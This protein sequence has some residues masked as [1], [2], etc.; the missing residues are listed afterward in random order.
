M[1]LEYSTPCEKDAKKKLKVTVGLTSTD[2]GPDST[3]R[4]LTLVYAE[5]SSEW[6]NENPDADPSPPADIGELK[7]IA[8]KLKR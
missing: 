2:Q 4:I 5:P 8:E 6:A 3:G 1:T 7:R